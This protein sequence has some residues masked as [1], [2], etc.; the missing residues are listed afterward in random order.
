MNAVNSAIYQRMATT[1]ALTGLLGRGSKSIYHL[2][3]P[4]GAVFPYVVFNIQ[5]G[6]DENL[7]PHRVKIVLHSIRAYSVSSSAEA[8]SIDAQIDSAFHLKPL[9]V[10]GWSDLWLARETDLELIDQQPSGQPVYMSGGFYRQIS[11]K[12]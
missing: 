10:T 1:S 8:G 6:G 4:D 3:A 2:Q 11:E 5:G 7:S 12:T 9:T